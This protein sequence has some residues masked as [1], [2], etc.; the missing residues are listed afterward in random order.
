MI[1]NFISRLFPSSGLLTHNNI[2][3]NKPKDK[4]VKGINFN[5]QTVT[6]DGHLWTSYSSALANGLSVPDA[7]ALTTSVKPKPAADRA[8]RNMLNTVV[9]KSHT[10]E[11]RQILPNGTYD[12]YLWII[13]NYRSNHHAMEVILGD[14]TVAT[15][16]GTLPFQHWAKYGPY[17]TTVTNGTLNLALSTSTSEIDAHI[18][19]MA[20]FKSS[21]P[22]E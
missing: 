22:E 15:A 8:T 14:K 7:I 2:D 12:V 4:F 13:E 6:I 19:G 17:S 3:S 11:I 10:L 18:M 9:C 1:T 16:I 5:G 20:I 21:S